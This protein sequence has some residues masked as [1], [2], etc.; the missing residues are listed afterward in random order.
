MI[1]LFLDD[2]REPYDNSWTC[3]RTYSEAI[4]LLKR[5]DV[6]IISLDHDLGIEHETGYDVLVWLEERVVKNQ[7]KPPEILIHSQNPVGVSR[8]KSAVNSIKKLYTRNINQ[9]Y[10]EKTLK[11]AR[12]QYTRYGE[13][14]RSVWD[15]KE[16]QI[17]N[18]TDL[19]MIGDLNYKSVLDLGCGFGDLY[20]FITDNNIKI[21]DYLG[22]DIFSE[23]NKR[24][25]EKFPN[26]NFEIKNIYKE[27]FKESEFDYVFAS[28][29]FSIP[30]QEWDIQ[31]TSTIDLIL[32]FARIGIGFNLLVS[33]KPIEFPLYYTT[34]KNL[35]PLIER[36]NPYYIYNKGND[37]VTIFINKN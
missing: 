22:V 36:Y 1:K 35:Y 30:L 20:Q 24:A 33:E 3:V 29:I 6:S 5:N 23:F 25:K 2:V 16:T 19:L 28:G 7:I 4:E 34:M 17:S 8:M 14:I 15:R 26:G 37:T 18:F 12:E 9:Q 32:Y 10:L 21:K 27:P 11:F 31:L 13:N